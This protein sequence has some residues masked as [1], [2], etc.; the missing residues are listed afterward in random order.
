MDHSRK[1]GVAERRCASGIWFVMVKLLC[2]PGAGWSLGFVAYVLRG[3]PTGR[4]INR[5]RC[6]RA[7]THRWPIL[8]ARKVRRCR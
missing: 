3:R 4:L 6:R 1:I 8:I 2:T 5:A 7:M